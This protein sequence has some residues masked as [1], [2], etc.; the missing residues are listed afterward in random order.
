MR[1]DCGKFG[2]NLTIT[3]EIIADQ[4]CDFRLN[5][6]SILFKMLACLCR[7]NKSLFYKQPRKQV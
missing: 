6:Q 1:H 4:Y 5:L 2:V 7:K 3:N